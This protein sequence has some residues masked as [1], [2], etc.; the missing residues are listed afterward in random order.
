MASF[1]DWWAYLRISIPS[2]VMICAEFYAFDAIMV[3]AGLIGVKEIAC[4]TVII[5]I[6]EMVYNV[7][8]G[9]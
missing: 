4:N 1:R 8:T 5:S 7:A 6:Y 2:T 9:I 3:M